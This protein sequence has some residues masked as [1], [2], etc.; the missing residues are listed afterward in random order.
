MISNL[1]F[2]QYA[3]FDKPDIIILETGGYTFRVYDLP[4]HGSA[5]QLLNYPIL[6]G[7]YFFSVEHL[8]GKLSLNSCTV[9]SYSI[10]FPDDGLRFCLGLPFSPTSWYYSEH[11]VIKFP[12]KAILYTWE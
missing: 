11:G 3:Q 12:N 8:Q 4:K 1:E 10:F 5:T 2:D 6:G 7:R 9:S